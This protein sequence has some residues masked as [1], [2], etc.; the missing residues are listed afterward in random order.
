MTTRWNISR[1]TMLRALGATVALPV[2]DVM[3]PAYAN[4]AASTA[5]TRMG[6]FYFP[7]GIPEGIWDPAKVSSNGQLL[8]LNEWMSPLEP[9]KQDIII[10][11]NL[12]TPLGNGHGPGTAT[13][14]TGGDYNRRTVNAGGISVDQ[15][16][17]KHVGQDTLLP[18]LELSLR[19]EGFFSNSLPR[20]AISWSEKGMPLS[21]EV[22][23]RVIFDR[24]FSTSSGGV[25]NRSV[26][27]LVLEEARSLNKRVSSADRTRLDDY[28]A[29]I[30]ALEKRIEFAEKRSQEKGSDKVLTDSLITPSP[31][32][33]SE[34][35]EYVQLMMDLIV[36]AFQTNATRVCTF[37][38]D[39]GQSNRYFNFIDNV[40]GTWH[41]LS[42]YK[43][44]SG[45]TEDD[46]G[47]TSWSSVAEKRAMFAEVN[48]WHHRQMA[49]LFGK[50][51]AVREP[52]GRTL[53]ENSMLVYGSN[54]ADGNQHGEENLPMIIAGS[55]G[56][57]IKSGRQLE[58]RDR[59]DMSQ[60]HL[61]MLQRMG[62]K[63]KR[64]AR[65][66]QP[67]DQLDG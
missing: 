24:M 60:L 53:L 49:Y 52:D 21:R 14:L 46:D 5:N 2:L 31:G 58:F 40:Q 61:A 63:A 15:L 47:V 12:W 65:A 3:D 55:G 20:N 19:G 32:I 10:P 6:Y 17:A 50:M 59:T 18:S 57:T 13:W 23:P 7:N 44:A 34:H 35:E 48:R 41:A 30:R 25:T 22:E 62:V 66:K 26:L 54:L 64:F 38:L 51:K 39:H 8:K 11:T 4:A 29:S 36:L 1:R 42:H 37:M 16:A 45:K 43:D 9:F 33:P 67:L 28:F 56:G 27:D